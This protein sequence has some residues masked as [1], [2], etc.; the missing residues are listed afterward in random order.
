MKRNQV[1][2]GVII[3]LVVAGGSFYA[4]EAMAK[5]PTPDK[6]QFATTFGGGNA[7]FTTRLGGRGANGGFTAGQI[8][9]TA[10][11]SIS[12]QQ[13]NGSSSEIVLISPTTQILKQTSGTSADLTNGT[14]VT[15]TGTSNSDG[16][17][18]ATSISIRPTIIHSTK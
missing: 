14:N 2:G 1:I 8:V 15:V 9:S 18:T 13:Q 17:L 12:I 3:L 10:N 11:G 5:N 16:S 4:G 6:G 7:G